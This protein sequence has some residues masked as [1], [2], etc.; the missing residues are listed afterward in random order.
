MSEMRVRNEGSGKLF[1]N[2]VL[3]KLTRTYFAFPVIMYFV[4]SAVSLF[5]GLS[6]A[7]VDPLNILF[8]YPLGM[9]FFSLVE[10]LIHRFLFHFDADT[11]KKKKLQ[12]TIHG[13][14]HEFPKDKDRLAMPPLV[15]VFLAGFFLLLFLV[16]LGDIAWYFYAGF[17]AGY[18]VYL[19]IHFAVHRYKPPQ[20]VFRIL[21]KH[22][23]LHHYKSMEGYYSVSFPF[24]DYLFGTIQR[25]RKEQSG[26]AVYPE[27]RL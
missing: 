8:L 12:Y 27:G 21:W 24:W 19:L 18:S 14:H 1:R 4:V 25:G 20:N 11:D 22:H 16:T 7:A 5:V 6:V 9:I 13:V 17:V 10:Y 15:S 26:G 23:A 2:P 3:E